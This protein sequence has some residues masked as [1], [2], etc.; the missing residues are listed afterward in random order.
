[1][2]RHTVLV[3]WACGL[4]SLTVGL[5]AAPDVRAEDRIG[6]DIQA[7]PKIGLNPNEKRAVSVAANRILMHV[8]QAR[9]DIKYREGKDALSQVQKALTLVKII[10][11]TVPT[12]QVKA[13]IK[14]GKLTYEDDQ[15][16]R[17][18]MVPIYS[19]LDEAPSTLPALKRTRRDTAHGETTESGPMGVTETQY[20]AVLL[21]VRQAQLDLTQAENALKK[22]DTQA[23][24]DSLAKIEDE[25]IFEYDEADLP[26]VKVRWNLVEAT[27]MIAA[28]RYQQA[29]QELL[30]AAEGL[31]SYRDKAGEDVSK[32]TKA[33]ADNI[34]ALAG[35]LDEKTAGAVDQIKSVWDKVAGMF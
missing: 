30:K 13:T 21:D 24:D 20:T 7:S 16:I 1:M 9:E 6:F 12:F 33:L 35:K 34:K 14:S 10:E 8:R 28:R 18:L 15:T 11:N 2:L 32:T 22:G 25:V 23:A 5:T 31:E 3:A 29:K 19:E 26:L 27:R 4:V 17:P